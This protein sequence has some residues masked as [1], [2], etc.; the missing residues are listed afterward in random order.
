MALTFRSSVNETFTLT[1]MDASGR[2]RI[3]T[4]TKSPTDFH[5]QLRLTHPSGRNWPAQF[6]GGNVLDAMAELLTS[7]D[8]E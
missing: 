3:V 5:W 1:G 6:H 8:I 2:K 4:A 7:R